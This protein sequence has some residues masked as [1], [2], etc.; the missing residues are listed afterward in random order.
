M[1]NRK[2]NYTW[3]YVLAAVAAGA[4]LWAVSQEMPF[5]EETVEQPLANTFAK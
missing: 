3:V 1:L 4:L 5:H 2:K